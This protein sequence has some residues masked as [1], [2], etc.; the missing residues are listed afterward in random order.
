MRSFVCLLFLASS[1]L[2]ISGC[3]KPEISKLLEEYGVLSE[4]IRTIE[5]T[6]PMDKAAFDKA[7]ERQDAILEEILEIDPAATFPDTGQSIMEWQ[8]QHSDLENHTSNDL[9]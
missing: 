2:F 8:L 4:E 5:L 7:N 1:S 3:A 6:E 9:F